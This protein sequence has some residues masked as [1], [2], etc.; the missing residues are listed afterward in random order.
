M[1]KSM[2]SV[3]NAGNWLIKLVQ[4]GKFASI[5][6]FSDGVVMRKHNGQIVSLNMSF[7]KMKMANL[8]FDQTAELD[9]TLMMDEDRQRR[10]NHPHSWRSGWSGHKPLIREDT[11][12]K[13]NQAKTWK[14]PRQDRPPNSMKMNTEVEPFVPSI[15]EGIGG[16][17]KENDI[18][19][20]C[21]MNLKQ[22][23]EKPP[24]LNF[25]EFKSDEL[26]TSFINNS[27]FELVNAG[28]MEH[29]NHS[30]D[31]P[32]DSGMEN[33]HVHP[34]HEEQNTAGTGEAQASISDQS[35]IRHN[36]EESLGGFLSDSGDRA[37]DSRKEQDSIGGSDLGVGV[38]V[39]CGPAD[40]D[41]QGNQTT[42]PFS[43]SIFLENEI[44]VPTAHYKTRLRKGTHFPEPI[45]GRYV[46][47]M[48]AAK[49]NFGKRLFVEAAESYEKVSHQYPTERA[50]SNCVVAYARTLQEGYRNPIVMFFALKFSKQ[51]IT[52]YPNSQKLRLN[53]V[54]V[55]FFNGDYHT[56]IQSTVDYM[57]QFKDDNQELKGMSV[58]GMKELSIKPYFV[59]KYLDKNQYEVVTENREVRHNF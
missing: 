20:E 24:E 29:N 39:D 49:S 27:N 31:N 16:K 48:D 38:S 1:K 57:E 4:Q 28:N 51:A 21:S 32:A 15:L 58:K 44:H 47:M 10:V 25:E 40:I 22:E 3:K 11:D 30:D 36:Q 52:L 55:A 19:L 5:V 13:L 18:V 26:T 17:E 6:P 2:N 33:N 9:R 8:N 46:E 41:S 50:V 45:N 14:K 7:S 35:R 37:D 42:F 56:T 23:L 53:A 59:D 54:K 43:R 12:N 34:V